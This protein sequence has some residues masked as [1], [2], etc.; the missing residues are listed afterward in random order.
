MPTVSE[1]RLEIG[2]VS[3]VHGLRGEVVVT[4]TTNVADRLA[5]GVVVD[6][7]HGQLVVAECR[8]HLE[9]WLVRFEG[10]ET[11]EDAEALGRPT[12]HGEPVEDPEALW[13][14][15]MIGASVIEADGTERGTVAGVQDN[16]AADL[17]V[18]STGALVPLNF[19]TSMENG[20][21]V[22]DVPDGLFDLF[23]ES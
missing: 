20:V 7:D 22:V 12:L 1:V 4:L 23:D 11:R 18:L 2:R 6:T 8:P 17:L 21:I 9:K 14:H 16:P 19:V 15:E 10:V 13:V 3:K 5:P